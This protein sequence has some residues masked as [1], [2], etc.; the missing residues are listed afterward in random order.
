MEDQQEQRS[1]EDELADILVGPMDDEP[2]QEDP[3]PVIEEEVEAAEDETVEDDTTEEVEASDETEEPTTVE[4]EIDGTLYEVPAEL[5]DHILRQQDYT[6][7]TQEVA[8]TRKELEIQRAEVAQ[9][10]L[11]YKFVGEVQPDLLKAQQLEAQAEQAHQYLR[12]NIDSLSSTDIEKIRLAVDDARRERDTLV[13]SIQTKQQ[14]F[15]QAQE[16]SRQEL[17]KKGTEVLRSRIPGWS[18]KHAQQVREFALSNGFT[19]ADVNSVVDPRQV[20]VLWKASQ[21]DSLQAGKVAAVKK[22]QDAPTI[23]AKS[24]NPMPKETQRALNL[25]KKLKN[26][27]LS[28]KQKAKLMEQDFADRWA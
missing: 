28:D 4:M 1:V 20:E 24:R 17:L 6:Q 13:Q 8:A 7:K 2:V 25:R 27:N 12:D 9:H 5:K 16:Q 22:V 21:F 11:Q 14:E 10:E 19:E 18:E 3:Q 15:Q 23:K 26:P